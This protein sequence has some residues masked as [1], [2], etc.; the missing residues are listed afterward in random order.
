MKDILPRTLTPQ[1]QTAAW[2]KCKTKQSANNIKH[3][4][5]NVAL[6]FAAVDARVKG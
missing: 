4:G 2:A 5:K 6:K 3:N 1:L